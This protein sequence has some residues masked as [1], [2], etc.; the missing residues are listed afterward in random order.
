[1]AADSSGN[2][3]IADGANNRTQEIAVASG[4][5]WGQSMTAGDIYTV[6][7]S[8]ARAGSVA[9]VSAAATVTALAV[10]VRPVVAGARRRFIFRRPRE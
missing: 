10:I 4:T 1:M 2:L 7:G 5:Q 8:A 6:G 9:A 3:Y